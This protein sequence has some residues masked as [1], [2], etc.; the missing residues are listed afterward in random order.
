MRLH[1]GVL[2]PPVVAG[3]LKRLKIAFRAVQKLLRLSTK[4]LMQVLFISC[5][6]LAS[7]LTLLLLTISRYTCKSCC[8]S[9]Q[10]CAFSLL[11]PACT[12]TTSDMPGHH[13]LTWVPAGAA[14]LACSSTTVAGAST[15]SQVWSCYPTARAHAAAGT[16]QSAP[17]SPQGRA[18]RAASLWCP[19]WAK[20]ERRLIAGALA[21]AMMPR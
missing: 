1:K 5:T 15:L 14:V 12:G 13:S 6:S 21:L 18:V 16:Q 19:P 20:S 8:T 3:F 4:M 10:K 9:Q 17:Q 11:L 2:S 7:H